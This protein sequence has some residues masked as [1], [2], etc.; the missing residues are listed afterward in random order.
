MPDALIAK[1]GPLTD[2]EWERVR[3]HPEIG[4][5]MLA[6]TDFAD[7]GDWILAHHERPDGSGYPRGRAAGEVPLEAS[8]LGV[9]DAYE[10]M[11]ARRPYRPPLDPEAASEEL[12]RGAGMQF[13]QRVVDA[14]LRVV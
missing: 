11:T 5:R 9:A 4:A 14:L 13:D 8:I 10:A 12:R 1:A 3:S 2:E 7:I 6:T